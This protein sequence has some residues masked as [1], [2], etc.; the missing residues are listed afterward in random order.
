[1]G[2]PPM[3]VA[4]W[5]DWQFFASAAETSHGIA[6]VSRGGA[7]CATAGGLFAGGIDAA[8]TALAVGFSAGVTLGVLLAVAPA[9]TVF[10]G[11]MAGGTEEV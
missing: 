10:A 11:G 6:P 5:H 3:G 7:P 9:L 1:M 8:G 2:A 4:A